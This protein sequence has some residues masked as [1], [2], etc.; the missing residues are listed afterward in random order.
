M[1]DGS[2][3]TDCSGENRPGATSRDLVGDWLF[4]PLQYPGEDYDLNAAQA[5][6]H[7]LRSEIKELGP[8]T[9]NSVMAKAYLLRFMMY[10]HICAR[11]WV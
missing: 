9:L 4:G 1:I 2:V 7:D 6:Y 8:M 3:L 11:S 10:I 5:G